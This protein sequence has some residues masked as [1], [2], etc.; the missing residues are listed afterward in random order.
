MAARHRTTCMQVDNKFF[1]GLFEPARK[2]AMK[3]LGIS[4]LGQREF[5]EMIFKSG[6]SLDIKLNSP[7]GKKR[8]KNVKKNT[9][10]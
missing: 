6:M 5:S 7:I 1:D 3:K 8:I 4:K 2:R 10:R 9:K